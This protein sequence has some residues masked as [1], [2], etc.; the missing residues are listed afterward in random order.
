MIDFVSFLREYNL[1]FRCP[2]VGLSL[3]F[4]FYTPWKHQKNV[5]LWRF[6]GVLKWTIGLNW[7]KGNTCDISQL[8]RKPIICTNLLLFGAKYQTMEDIELKG[9]TNKKQWKLKNTF[10]IRSTLLH[11]LSWLC[12]NFKL[13]TSINMKSKSKMVAH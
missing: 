4:H 8:F 2:R 7:V 5:V 3:M 11:F 10:I 9:P 12:L 1:L 6:Q 13:T